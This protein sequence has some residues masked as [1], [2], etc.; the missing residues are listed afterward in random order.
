MADS[1]QPPARWEKLRESSLA[2]TRIFDLRS[3]VYRHPVRQTERD[4]VVIHA[5][6]WVNVLAVTEQRELVLVNQF[7]YGIDAFSLEIPGGVIDLGEDPI[8]AGVREL[9]EE[10]GFVGGKARLLGSV[11]PNPAIMDNRCHLVLV[12]NC[13][14]SAELEWDADEEIEV[15][16]APVDDVYAWSRSGRIQHSLVLN[17]LHLFAPIWQ[18]MNKT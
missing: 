3:A 16:T 17:A 11:R 6:D 9:R 1:R 18:Q 2:S 7:R 5:P 14:R 8:E 10:T 15:S 12:E 13:T 4:F